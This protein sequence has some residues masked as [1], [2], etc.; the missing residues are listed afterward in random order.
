M[1]TLRKPKIKT[2]RRL[3][4]NIMN[5]YRI[6][7]YYKEKNVCFIADSNGRFQAL[8]EFSA[9]LVS[10]GIE[11]VAVGKS[12]RLAYSNIP[13]AEPDSNC[14]IIR[15]CAMGRPDI[16]NGIITVNGKFYTQKKS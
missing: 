16:S 4:E 8:W 3:K 14:I 7:G 10:K 13:S 11:I 2:N 6:T 9:F 12:E 15:A 1:A 5:Y